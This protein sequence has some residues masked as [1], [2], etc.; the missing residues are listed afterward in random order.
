M[1]KLTSYLLLSISLFLFFS[2]QKELSVEQPPVN[3]QTAV[4]S[5]T[6]IPNTCSNTVVAGN[7]QKGKALTEA[8]KVSIFVDVKTIGTYIIATA[9]VNGISFKGRGVFTVIGPQVIVLT[10]GGIPLVEGTFKYLPATG[11]CLFSIVILDTNAATAI[12]SYAGSTGA[13]TSAIPNGIYTAGAVLTTAN[14]IIIGIYVNAIGVYT[15]TT[16]VVNGFSF[17]GS[18]NL[19]TTGNQFVT[20]TAIGRPVAAGTI[21]FTPPNGCSFVVTVLPSGSGSNNDIYFEATIDGVYYKQIVTETNGYSEAKGSR[22][23]LENKVLSSIISRP[24]DPIPAGATSMSISK[25]ILHDYLN[26][27]PEILKKFFTPGFYPYAAS[28][29]EDGAGVGWEDPSGEFWSSENLPATQTGSLFNLVSTEEII[30]PF[31]GKILKLT[32]TFN[33]KLYDRAGNVKTLTNGKFVGTIY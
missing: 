1:L 3:A 2:C 21:K 6:G 32:A 10:G 30:T 20:L 25:G 13:C 14:T 31:Y 18:G 24:T 19:A 27:T 28:S 23:D 33:C 17:V 12:F 26:V 11:S 15:I 9:V 5:F 16:P 7:Y 8:N 4:Y 29:S 22:G